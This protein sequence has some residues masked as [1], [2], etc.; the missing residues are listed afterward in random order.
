M[1]LLQTTGHSHGHA[2]ELVLGGGDH[3]VGLAQGGQVVLFPGQEAPVQH[4][5]PQLAP[6]LSKD[7]WGQRT[8]R[9]GE[10]HQWVQFSRRLDFVVSLRFDDRG[11]NHMIGYAVD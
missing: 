8:T 7:L 11:L 3:H 2:E 6:G 4:M 9:K 10:T 5:G 1:A